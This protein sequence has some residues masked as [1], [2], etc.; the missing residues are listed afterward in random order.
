M[1]VKIKDTNYRI[2]DL[3]EFH[4]KAEVLTF[5]M[6]MPLPQAVQAMIDHKQ[7]AIVVTG[8]KNQK[9][10]GIVTE[11][12]LATKVLHNRMNYDDLTLNDVMTGNVV[13]A[14]QNDSVSNSMHR[15]SDGAFRHMPVVDDNGNLTGMLTEGDF[16][17]Y[18]WEDIWRRLREETNLVIHN[19]YQPL[20]IVA[21]LAAYTAFVLII[22]YFMSLL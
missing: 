19:R 14:N 21:G 8:Q 11:H 17:A 15:L 16:V 20:L 6:N 5:P 10:K 12:D 2:V 4:D 3:P 13:T 1:A 7:S 18:T 22:L 9:V